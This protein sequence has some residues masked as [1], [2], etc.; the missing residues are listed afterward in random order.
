MPRVESM[1]RSSIHYDVGRR[2]SQRLERKSVFGSDVAVNILLDGVLCGLCLDEKQ[3]IVPI[4]RLLEDY[5]GKRGQKS[6]TS[7]FLG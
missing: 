6:M 5:C 2:R 1:D 7:V 3:P 4:T